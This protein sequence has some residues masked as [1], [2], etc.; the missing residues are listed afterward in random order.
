MLIEELRIIQDY[1][2][3]PKDVKLPEDRFFLDNDIKE[4][5]FWLKA[6]IKNQKLIIS[7][8]I[9]DHPCY[10]SNKLT[11]ILRTGEYT[12]IEYYLL[13]FLIN[14]TDNLVKMESSLSIVKD[15]IDE[16]IVNGNTSSCKLNSQ[17]QFF[18]S[19]MIIRLPI[20]DLSDT[21]IDF[22]AEKALHND[23][24]LS[25]QITD[26]FFPKLLESG[27]KDLVKKVLIKW[28]FSY[29]IKNSSFEFSQSPILLPRFYS[30]SL[31][32]IISDSKKI[33]SLI[34]IIGANELFE[35]SLGLIKEV[36]NKAPIKFHSI[37]IPT[38]EKS[39]QTVN[40]NDF[41]YL[42]VSFIREQINLSKLSKKLV[43]SL[44]IS[45]VSIIKR[46][47][48][49]MIGLYYVDYKNLFWNLKVYNPLNEV[50]SK[51][52]IFSLLKENSEAIK[53][54]ELKILFNWIDNIEI[55]DYDGDA[56]EIK[57]LKVIRG[58]EYIAALEKINEEFIKSVKDKKKELDKIYPYEREHPGYNSYFTTRVGY[59][60]PDS[61]E[62]FKLYSNNPQN[63]VKKIEEDDDKWDWL[64]KE[65]QQDRLRELFK[66]NPN[67]IKDTNSLAKL[68]FNYLSNIIYG[69]DL[70]LKEGKI[71][72]WNKII[73]LINTVINSGKFNE[74]THDRNQFVG[75]V[76]WLIRTAT[77]SDE[78]PLLKEH[79]SSLKDICLK[80]LKLNTHSKRLNNDPFF[81]VLNSS[82]GK[83][84]DATLNVLL[85][86]ARLY[87]KNDGDKW[88][89]EIKDYYT[90]VLN[91]NKISEAFLWSV[92]G[93]LPQFGFLHM[94]WLIEN[95]DKLFPKGNLKY[96][97]LSMR[98]Y[99]RMS[100]TV[101]KS[102]FD[103]LNSNGHYDLA[104]KIFINKEEGTRD[105]ISHIIVS[106]IAGWKE[107]EIDNSNGLL[108][109]I[110]KK[111]EWTQIES[112]INYFITNKNIETNRLI[113]FWRLMVGNV[114]K[115]KDKIGRELLRLSHRI[116]SIDDEIYELMSQTL[117]LLDDKREL[118]ELLRNLLKS[119][120]GDPLKRAKL[121]MKATSKDLDQGYYIDDDI[122][123]LLEELEN[124][125][126]LFRLNFIN[127][128]V[129][130][131]LFGLFDIYYS[132]EL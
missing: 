48:Y 65:G 78:K 90:Y 10:I 115:E 56:D 130:K 49:Y 26:V 108:N 91:N 132:E 80:L 37:N 28:I 18:I 53:K 116:Y 15:I 82:E 1:I 38:I 97:K 35:L 107:Q 119:I 92:A 12:K 125:D 57:K 110:I 128:M 98:F 39:E 113:E 131:R 7:D 11:R 105:I 79:L 17:V 117:D 55:K 76:G 31:E 120:K 50:E 118:H 122:K 59:D 27:N 14:L 124:E 83:V 22:I 43:T 62:E 121:I 34:E 25:Y 112:A 71:I 40:E 20:K 45:E 129:S 61:D 42:L 4:E 111:Q 88:I 101:Y 89:K 67:Y 96:W 94:D 63:L 114:E 29:D 19:K 102:I 30:Y 44:L 93:H 41:S 64:E 127:D 74:S 103:L 13:V 66:E 2:N 3:N 106:Y 58:K 100:S 5:F 77:E 46:F 99:H 23:S 52:E 33:R 54:E 24:A 60:Y 81:D 86:N 70:A 36:I 68:D 84:F 6:S 126:V 87:K 123:K 21:Y 16:Y 69:L 104:L 73:K 109:R 8:F 51:Y 9:K 95:I 47:G 85:Q 32:N 75:Y 72:D